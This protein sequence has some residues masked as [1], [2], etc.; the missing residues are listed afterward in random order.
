MEFL[1]LAVTLREVVMLLVFVFT[2]GGVY[3]SITTKL[4]NLLEKS[5]KAETSR[6][7]LKKDIVAMELKMEAKISAVES[8][9]LA[10]ITDSDRRITQGEINAARENERLISMQNTLT[11]IHELVKGIV[12]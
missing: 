9:L 11:Q 3:W 10:K 2:A 4:E 12:R 1:G 5:N 6:D 7:S 8:N